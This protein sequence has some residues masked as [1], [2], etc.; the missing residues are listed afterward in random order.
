MLSV[1]K[2]LETLSDCELSAWSEWSTCSAECDGG[3]QKRTRHVAVKAR[4]GGKP[5]E[6]VVQEIRG[7]RAFFTYDW[8]SYLLVARL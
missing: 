4:F 5:C 6:E 1:R 3:E 2:T 7:A 8:V